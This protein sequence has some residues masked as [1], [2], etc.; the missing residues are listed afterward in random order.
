MGASER[1]NDEISRAAGDNDFLFLVSIHM[2]VI[3]LQER[4]KSDVGENITSA[5]NQH[6]V[7]SS[8]ATTGSR[9]IFTLTE[10][11]FA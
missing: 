6:A 5:C 11:P 1:Q 3:K 7:C 2:L 10:S 8:Y 9:W 4:S